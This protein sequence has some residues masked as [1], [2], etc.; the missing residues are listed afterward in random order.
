VKIT[1]D[2]NILVRAITED[3]PAQ[4][5]AAKAELAAADSV[6]ITLPVLCELV[7]VLAQGYRIAAP[8]IAAVIRRLMQTANVAADRPGVEAGLALLEAG[9]D[10][11]DGVIA[12]QGRWLGASIFVSFD[13]KAVRLLAAQGHMARVP[14]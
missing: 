12:H 3:D 1:A 9:G 4:S 10:F 14:A 13:R 5:A 7:W 11:A 2:T 8:D 6:A